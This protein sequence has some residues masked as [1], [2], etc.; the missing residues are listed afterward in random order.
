MN[1]GYEVVDAGHH[2][3]GGGKEVIKTEWKTIRTTFH[4]FASLPAQRGEVVSSPTLECHGLR[5]KLDVYPGGD[6]ASNQNVT[7]VS[8]YLRC[9]SSVEAGKAVKAAYVLRAPTT[10]F[11]PSGTQLASSGRPLTF[12]TSPTNS[13]WGYGNSVVRDI[14]LHPFNN[15][16]I[17]GSLT[18]EADIQVVLD[19]FPWPSSNPWSNNE[20]NE[21]EGLT[22]ADWKRKHNETET[23]LHKELSQLSESNKRLAP[24]SLDMLRLLES[25][26]NADVIFE[27]GLAKKSFRAHRLILLTRCPVLA[28]LVEDCNAGDPIPIE[29]IDPSMFL[30]L[31]RFVYG[32]EVPGKDAVKKDAQTIIRAADRFGCTGLKLHAEA[33][34]AS[35]DISTNEVAELI[36]FADATNC[37]LLKEAAMD[38]FVDDVDGVMASN[39]YEQVKESPSIMAEMM[40]AMASAN[41]KRPTSNDGDNDKDYKR[42]RVA[43]LRE[44]L[45]AKRLDIDG[46]KEMLVSRLKEAEKDVVEVE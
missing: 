11:L 19:N 37:A 45:A 20:C 16:L 34:L 23:L 22:A 13:Y 41:K 5:W 28:S 21:V 26:D 40:A 24:L 32:G 44:K 36:L 10:G 9:L 7:N 4:N 42:M 39:G 3:G 14:L 17:S 46:S 2:G 1:G 43:T 29:G 6:Y 18:I 38:K 27:V 15:Y 8:L 35:A 31:L 33:E 12:G 25:G 30:M